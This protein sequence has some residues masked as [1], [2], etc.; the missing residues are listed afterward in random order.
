MT[1]PTTPPSPPGRP[2][3][4][5]L[6][7][8]SDLATH[9]AEIALPLEVDGAD[10][11]RALRT[12]VLAQITT[13]LLPRLREAATPAILVVGGPTG[14][15][16]STLVNSL[17]GAQVSASGVLRPTTRRP[18]L[19]VHPGDVERLADHPVT[20]LADVVTASG[21]PAGIALLDAPD[22]DSVEEGN[23]R[24]AV[25]LVEVADL[26][27]FVTTA[28][29]YGDALPWTVLEEVRR[30]G[31]TIAVVLDRVAADV[32]GEVRRDLLGR[33]VAAGF[34]AVPLLIVPDAGPIDGAL[35]ADHTAEVRRWLDLVATRAGAQGVTARTLRGVWGP[36]REEVR[37]LLDAVLAQTR[38]AEDLAARAT[39]ASTAASDEVG[40]EVAGGALADGGP[41]TRWLALA[42]ARGPLEPLAHEVRGFLARRRVTRG[43]ADRAAALAA[44]RGEVERSFDDVVGRAAASAHDAVATD[45]RA[46]PAGAA[47]LAR[48]T[49]DVARRERAD[50]LAHARTGW[51]DDVA[52]LAAGLTVPDGGAADV[53]LED[54]GA[55]TLL[56]LAAAGVDGAVAAVARRWRS[57][58]RPPSRR[59]APH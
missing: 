6:E 36:L 39:A 18:V 25:E 2:T 8:A 57:A 1:T 33:L 46:D 58:G 48:R 3:G 30:R 17:A 12:R 52:R 4:P 24:L 38:A 51:V 43:G 21:I 44:L 28:T 13:H 42:G 16:K 35:P 31:V 34:D 15:G 20:H 22:L 53:E 5:A 56:L 7:V 10:H 14:A 54:A 27:L 49:G 19:V 37:E 45:W 23:R 9:L 29:R 11:A 50:R 32:V 40:R 59:R 55:A 47:L 41:T 26:W